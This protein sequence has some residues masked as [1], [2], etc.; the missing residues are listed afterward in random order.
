MA[1][2]F[3]EYKLE[4]HPEGGKTPSFIEEGGYFHDKE[5]HTIVGTVKEG[6]DVPDTITYMTLEQLQARQLKIH[7]KEPM[8]KEYNKPLVGLR[9]LNPHKP[10][11][12]TEDEVKADIKAWVA[13]EI[14]KKS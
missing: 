12:M 6:V 5:N 14:N 8:A 13:R 3:I 9:R 4:K 1:V 2:K 7:I 11:V 10:S